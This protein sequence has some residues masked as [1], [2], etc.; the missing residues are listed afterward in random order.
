MV[1]L[2]PTK[3]VFQESIWIQIVKLHNTH[4][5]AQSAHC[6][7]KNVTCMKVEREDL[8]QNCHLTVAMLLNYIQ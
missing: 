5:P 1:L 6:T 3:Y 2:N 4:T 8:Q 7:H